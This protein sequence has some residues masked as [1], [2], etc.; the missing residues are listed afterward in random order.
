MIMVLALALIAA[1]LLQ[2]AL[3]FRMWSGAYYAAMPWILRAFPYGTMPWTM[4]L[5]LGFNGAVFVSLGALLLVPRPAIIATIAATVVAGVAE[6]VL[7]AWQPKWADPPSLNERGEL[8]GG[9][10]RPDGTKR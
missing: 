10:A 7:F 1:G 4:P 6:I 5:P 2:I 8:R 9:A 3:A